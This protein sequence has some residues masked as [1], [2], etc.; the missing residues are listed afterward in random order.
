VYGFAAVQSDGDEGDIDRRRDSQQRPYLDLSFYARLHEESACTITA[1]C[2]VVW[3]RDDDV[4]GR[5][6]NDS[7]AWQR[8]TRVADMPG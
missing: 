7:R 8:R 6:L 2:R 5:S 4:M 1:C 3:H